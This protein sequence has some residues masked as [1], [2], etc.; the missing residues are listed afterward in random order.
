[1]F[2]TGGKS[3]AKTGARVKLEPRAPT[4]PQQLGRYIDVC[5]YMLQCDHSKG[6]AASVVQ[7]TMAGAANQYRSRF[8][9]AR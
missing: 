7:A 1:M 6:I 8:A 9:T 4:M 3:Y 2:V 5:L